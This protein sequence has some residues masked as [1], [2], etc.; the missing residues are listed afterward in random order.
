MTANEVAQYILLHRG[1][2]TRVTFSSP[3]DG[4]DGFTK[5]KL[6]PVSMK[7]GAQWQAERFRDD[8]VFHLNVRAEDAEDYILGL[9]S[10]YCQINA[11]SDGSVDS[12]SRKG[13]GG[14]RMGSGAAGKGSAPAQTGNDRKKDYIIKEG[15]PVPALVELGVFTRDYR[16]VAGMYD[17]FKQINRFVEMVDDVFRGRSDSDMTILD[18]GCGKS[19]LTFVLYHYFAVVRG[20]N[21]RI[22]G[23]DL[24]P[25]VIKRCREVAER[26]GYNGL[27]FHVSDVTKNALYDEKI[28]MIVS[29]HA[30]DTATDYALDYGI[31]KNVRTI[32]SVPCCQHEV[33]GS[34]VPGGELDVFLRYGI[35]K[36][37][38]CAL[39]TDTVRA[40]IL[41]AEGY[42][43]DLL[44]F[45]DF[46]HSPKNIMIRA[47]KTGRPHPEK[48]DEVRELLG[49]YG[50]D[51]SLFR[52]R[53]EE[54]GSAVSG[55]IA[56]K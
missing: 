16:V 35:V 37:R 6:R 45:V 17:K 29:L 34:I 10:G 28:D 55:V 25:D 18:F 13:S 56:K 44:E 15:D 12:F 7:N 50:I 2:L 27:E 11:L 40:M 31:K 9:C 43:T 21:V 5:V 54:S 51:Q 46:S 39:L 52:L 42:R 1:T 22:I 47:Q 26:Y 30:C 19:Y 23:Y 41:E 49:R 38:M 32:I 8:K 20:I 33:N 48:M 4:E 14:F 24:K 3:D 36:E 53:Q